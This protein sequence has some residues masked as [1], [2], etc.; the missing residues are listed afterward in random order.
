MFSSLILIGAVCSK[1]GGNVEKEEIT[2]AGDGNRTH[3]SSLGSSHS[4]IEQHPHGQTG[5][6]VSK[7]VMRTS[8]NLKRRRFFYGKKGAFPGGWERKC[9]FFP[10]F[11]NLVLQTPTVLVESIPVARDPMV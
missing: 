3:V 1:D 4:T 10:F 6:E 11:P 9:L 7:M 8:R 5:G 2:G